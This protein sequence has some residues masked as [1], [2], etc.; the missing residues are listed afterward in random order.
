MEIVTPAQVRKEGMS[1]YYT[2]LPCKRGHTAARYLS[3]NCVE[4]YKDES[5]LIRAGAYYEKNRLRIAGRNLAYH[6]ANPD[7]QKRCLANQKRKRRMARGQDPDAPGRINARRPERA[8]TEEPLRV[9]IA[10]RPRAARCELCN[11][12][13]KTVFDHC[14]ISGRFRGW[15]CRRCN[16]T[17]GLAHDDTALLLRIVSYLGRPSPLAKPE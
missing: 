14:H 13:S 10:G 15:L 8:P 1:T 6:V 2:G 5:N 3:G 7:V 12:E 16:V 9:A 11:R 17:L 4:C